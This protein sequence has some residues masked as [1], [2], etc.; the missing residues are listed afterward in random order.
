[1]IVVGNGLL[2]KEFKKI[3]ISNDIV[4]FASGVSNSKELEQEPFDREELLLRETIKKYKN[5]KILY[6]STCSISQ[7]TTSPYIEHN[8]KMENIII[9]SGTSYYIFRLPQVIGIVDNNTLISFIARSSYRNNPLTIQNNA[10]RNL[11]DIEDV[12]RIVKEIIL[13]STNE[14]ITFN[15]SSSSYISVLSLAKKIKEVLNS[16]SLITE[17][18]GGESYKIDNSKLK[19]YISDGDIIFTESYPLKLLEKYIPKLVNNFKETWSK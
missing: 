4:V 8:I 2:A 6:F 19:E 9:E 18:C 16:D 1:L 11:I 14:S 13:C 10:Y 7:S 17:V 3:L 12:V 15:I 5:K